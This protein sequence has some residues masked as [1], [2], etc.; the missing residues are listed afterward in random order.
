ML[1]SV[2][3]GFHKQITDNCLLRNYNSGCGDS[4]PTDATNS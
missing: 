3:F 2:S 1:P 4:D